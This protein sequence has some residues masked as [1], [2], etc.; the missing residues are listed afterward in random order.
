MEDL[1]GI[2]EEV[3]E[4]IRRKTKQHEEDEAARIRLSS[5][6]DEARNA[7]GGNVLALLPWVDNSCREGQAKGMHMR[8]GP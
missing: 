7:A 4:V 2:Q 8:Q 6:F 1:A 3:V 5:G